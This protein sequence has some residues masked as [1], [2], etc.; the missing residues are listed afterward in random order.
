MRA[1]IPL[2][3]WV[4]CS[5][6]TQSNEINYWLED[7]GLSWGGLKRDYNGGF[8][9]IFL[10]A[11]ALL[12]FFFFCVFDF[13]KQAICNYQ[14]VAVTFGGANMRNPSGL[15]LLLCAKNINI[16]KILFLYVPFCVWSVF[17]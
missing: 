16:F 17:R 4:L 7:M 14:N 3:I 8:E 10:Q 11:F 2:I 1:H 5:K 6:L 15:V 12:I 13:G 9:T